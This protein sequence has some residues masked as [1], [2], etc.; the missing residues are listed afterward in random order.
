MEADV[1]NRNRFIP[2]KC[3]PI[4]SEVFRLGLSIVMPHFI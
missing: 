2:K 4:E 3:L 1:G